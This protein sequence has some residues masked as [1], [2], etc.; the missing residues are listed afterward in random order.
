MS[1]SSQQQMLG[2]SAIVVASI[3]W[4]TTGT[5]ATF[6][7]DV[8]P[9][10]IGAAAMGIGG[11]L[12]A[13]LALRG[14]R[15][16]QAALLAQTR[17][18]LLGAVMVAVYPLAFYSSM[19]LAG[20]AI[21]TV[22]TIGSAPLLSALIEWRLEG[23]RLTLRWF[24]GAGLG[25]SGMV[26]LSLADNHGAAATQDTGLILAG[27][28]LGVVAGLGYAFYSW[29]A[30][31]LMQAGIPSATAMGATFGLGGVLLMPILLATGAPLLASW[32][33]LGVGLYMALVPMFI[34]YLCFGSGL[35]RV[36][37]SIATTISLLEPVVAAILAIMVVGESLSLGGWSGVLL[38]IASLCCITV[39]RPRRVTSRMPQSTR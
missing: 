31:R 8:G 1:N 36:R 16:A 11:L 26:L 28:V 33:N 32:N 5:A 9:L 6:A 14:I 39:P 34:G 15:R 27:I 22:M 30:R 12:Q 13:A 17:H 20:V 19:R 38:I 37:A 2:I 29:S 7:P 18:V 4:G 10:A 24:A 23:L 25:L 21:G 3:L 35:A